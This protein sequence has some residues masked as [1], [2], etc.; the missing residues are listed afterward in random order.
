[1]H[2]CFVTQ[3]PSLPPVPISIRPP[4]VSPPECFRIYDE[5][6]RLHERAVRETYAARDMRD[7]ERACS[8]ATAFRCRAF[9]FSSRGRVDRNCQLTA[10]DAR[11]I[12]RHA[13]RS[14]QSMNFQVFHDE[15]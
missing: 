4:F 1:M 2:S 5:D 15:E 12:D 6:F 11:E 3:M 7:C 13:K 8:A 14:F 9:S 10:L